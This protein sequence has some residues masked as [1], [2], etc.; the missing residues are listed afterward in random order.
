MLN[1]KVEASQIFFEV[2]TRKL[3]GG[4]N[5]STTIENFPVLSLKNVWEAS[6]FEFN[7]WAKSENVLCPFKLNILNTVTTV[8]ASAIAVLVHLD[9]TLFL[10]FHLHYLHN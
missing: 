6:T 10:F 8:A 1:L 3:F 5:Y 4:S 7:I 2:I 9:I